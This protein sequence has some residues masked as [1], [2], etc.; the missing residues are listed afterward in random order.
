MPAPINYEMRAELKTAEP[1][2]ESMVT[3]KL[4]PEVVVVTGAS[5][6]VGCATVRAFARQ[7]ACIGLLA[8]GKAGLDGACRDVEQLGG[9]ALVLATDMAEGK[10]GPRRLLLKR[11]LARLTFAGQRR[12]EV[13]C[14]REK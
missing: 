12:G 1:T 14:I 5:A 11:N 13:F 9:K 4:Q 3:S 10:S 7:G 6:G 2:M 8:R